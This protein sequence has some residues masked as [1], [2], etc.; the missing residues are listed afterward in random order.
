MQRL[1]RFGLAAL[2]LAA[3]ALPLSIGTSAQAGNQQ[4]RWDIVSLDFGAGT[5]SAGGHASA[6]AADGSK[7]TLTGTGMFRSNPGKPQTVTGGGTWETQSPAG[8]VTGS[9]TYDVTGFV[10]FVEAPGTPPPLTNLILGA[11]NARAGLAF[12][13]IAY[14]DGSEGVLVVSCHLVGTPDSVFE[15]I[16]ASK[17]FIDYYDAVLPVP[18]VDDGRTLFSLV[19]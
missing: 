6:L 11:E 8:A 9:G 10:S 12:L 18:G 19:R 13:Q 16:T 14:S 1:N 4:I 17:G 5:L 3:V 7:I 2:L 15:G